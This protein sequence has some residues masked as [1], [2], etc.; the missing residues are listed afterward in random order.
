MAM[1]PGVAIPNMT[2]NG[3]LQEIQMANGNCLHMVTDTRKHN[4]LFAIVF[5]CVF[6]YTFINYKETFVKIISLKGD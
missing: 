6:L 1:A 4:F 2:G 3:I 5:M